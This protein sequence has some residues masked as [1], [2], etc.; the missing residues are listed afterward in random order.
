MI[1]ENTPTERE[2]SDKQTGLSASHTPETDA[3]EFPV[4]TWPSRDNPLVVRS[5][6]ARKLET[7]LYEA[8]SEAIRWQDAWANETELH[9]MGSTV[10]PWMREWKKSLPNVKEHTPLPASASDETA[11]PLT[12]CSPSFDDWWNDQKNGCPTL[13]LDNDEQFARA[14]WDA[15]TKQESA[16]RLGLT[17]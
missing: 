13:V 8:R 12:N 7:Q 2:I 11:L 6:L 3:A 5:T 9:E 16:L 4:L 1:N 17:S 15:A 14:V 10:M